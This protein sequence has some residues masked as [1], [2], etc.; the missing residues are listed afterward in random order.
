M[1]LFRASVVAAVAV[2]ALVRPLSA[3]TGTYPFQ[4]AWYWGVYGGQISFPTSVARTIAPTIGADWMITRTNYA[5][6]IFAEQSYFDAVSTVTD[7]QT[8]APRNVNIT[9]L[10]RIGANAM[11]FTP[12]VSII[13]PYVGLGYAFNFIREAN[14]QGTYY[15]TPAAKDTVDGRINAAKSA[16]KLFGQFGLMTTLG[17]WAPFAEYTVMPSQGAGSWFVN[18]DGFTSAWTLGVRF[19]FGSS[20]EK[21][22]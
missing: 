22:W 17:R 20:I 21:K 2:A 8:G 12:K 1:R 14:A 11:I 4:D 16:G 10:R 18:G 19:N 3:Q 7:F 6:H 9:D 13:R 5:L 15:S